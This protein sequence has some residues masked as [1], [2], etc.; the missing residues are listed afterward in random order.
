MGGNI[1]TAILSLAPPSPQRVH[2]VE[3]S[4]FQIDL[5]PGLRPDV[6]LLLNITPDHLD[7]HGTLESYWSIKH[8]SLR[9]PPTR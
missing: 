8:S 9:S 7:R 4:S 5:A 1:G 3:C 6:G 2:V